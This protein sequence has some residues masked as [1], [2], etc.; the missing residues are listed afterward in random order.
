MA[1]SIIIQ[2]ERPPDIGAR[3]FSDFSKAGMT[4][5]GRLWETRFVRRHFRAGA[6]SRYGYKTRSPGYLR[7]KKGLAAKGKVKKGGAAPL[8]FTGLLE[9]QMTRR[10]I[11]RAFP[12]RIT[13]RKPAGPYVT[14]RPQ[15]GR[16]NI[17]EE[18]TATVPE[19]DAR[20]DKAYDKVVTRHM[21]TFRARRTK[22]I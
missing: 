14:T 2:Q 4:V 10:G 21:N 20:M 16:P 19:E 1:F 12:T 9:E 6:A 13:I 18:I 3:R 5:A 17:P 22:K 7:K 11:L 15:N 8:V